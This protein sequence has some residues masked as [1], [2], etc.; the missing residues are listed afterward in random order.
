MHQ[1][2]YNVCELKLFGIHAHNYP[3]ASKNVNSRALYSKT[4]S[5]ENNLKQSKTLLH[6]NRVRLS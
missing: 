1:A 4:T 6:Y 3:A 5:S 2:K